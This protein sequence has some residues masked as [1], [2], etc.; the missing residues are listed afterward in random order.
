LLRRDIYHFFD[1]GLIAINP[2]TGQV[3]VHGDLFNFQEYEK[4]HLAKAQVVLSEG[5][6]NWL[7]IHWDL[8]RE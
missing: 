4:L 1:R 2:R 7:K 6:N 5:V 3:D 8:Y